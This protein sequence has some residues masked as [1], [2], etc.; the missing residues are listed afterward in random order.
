MFFK[1]LGSLQPRIRQPGFVFLFCLAMAQV[2]HAS[3]PLVDLAAEPTWIRLGHY[4]PDS[5][6][7]SGWQSAIHS[8]DF[9]LHADG[10]INPRLELEATLAAFAIPPANENEQHA[11]CRFPARWH[12]L[13]SKI[14]AHAAFAMPVKCNAFNAW[15]RSGNIE[16]LS[17]VLASG[18]L[19]NPASY[20][21][22]T[23]LKFNFKGDQGQ[24]R[25]MDI[26]V[27]Y[28]AIVEKN[29]GPFTYIAKSLSGGYDGGFSHIQFYFHNHNYGNIEL[30]D[31]WEYKI[32]LPA[33][34]VD[35]IVAHA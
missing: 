12:W 24:T 6:V 20:Y 9:F 35:L 27:N 29:D 30:R 31:L 18:Y 22:H 33:N 5:S 1:Y 21:G 10:R 23:L 2:A 26:S 7:S 14:G 8:S 17:V 16:S 15:T 34:E 3:Q 11:Q 13:R 28:G 32:D 19:G 25:L 4:E